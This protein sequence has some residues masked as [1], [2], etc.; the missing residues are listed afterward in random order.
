M[1]MT[2]SKGG[3]KIGNKAHGS[4]RYIKKKKTCGGEGTGLLEEGDSHIKAQRVL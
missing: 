2:N 1:G 3:K 4:D